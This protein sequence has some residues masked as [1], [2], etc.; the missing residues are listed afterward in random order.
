MISSTSE[1]S[2]LVMPDGPISFD[3]KT[4][5]SSKGERLYLDSLAK[6][7]K[8]LVLVT[9][10]LRAGDESYESNLHSS[11]DSENIKIIELPPPKNKKPSV[12][13]KAFQFLRVFMRV[14]VLVKNVD[15][16]YL[17]LP[18]Y[19]SALCWISLKLWRKPHIVYGADDWVQASESMFRWEVKN[20]SLFYK[21]YL[22]LNKLMERSLVRSAIFGVAAGGQL[23]E[24]YQS[25]GCNSYATTPRSTL[26]SED[27]YEREDTCQNNYIQL[28]NVGGL[29]HDKAQHQLL[30][31]FAIALKR[32]DRFRLSIIGEGP[33]REKLI[34][35]AETLGIIS[36]VDFIGYV[37]SES[38]LYKYLRS[39]DIF[40]LSSITEGF[41]RVLYEAMCMRLP[42]VT[43][44]VGGISHL[45]SN[46]KNA[47]VVEYGKNDDFAHAIC[48][49][50]ENDSL[51]KKIIANA[52]KTL[53]S[54]FDRMDMSQIS[55]LVIKHLDSKDSYIAAD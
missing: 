32:N 18:S 2:L 13:S 8:E 5:K 38:V 4:Y 20:K 51:R 34:S 22:K 49:M 15:I 6:D 7:F 16:G 48:M 17:F 45:M 12:V 36:K 10:V 9:F 39:A 55:K 50:A 19:P 25:F 40:V 54:V 23:V 33:E 3:G 1:L 43:T 31:S 29:I 11:F 46:K 47:L 24:K 41:P 26:S 35:L 44:N 28:I 21:A 42:I 37:E 27:I 30:R 52:S 14:F 53:D